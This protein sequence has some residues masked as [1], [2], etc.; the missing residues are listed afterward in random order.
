MVEKI[1][2][3]QSMAFRALRILGKFVLVFIEIIASIAS[4]SSSKPRYTASQAQE[5]YDEGLI[6]I[7]ELNK[8][9]HPK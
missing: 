1:K 9:I 8:S 5:L 2:L 3:Q 4:D 7:A 6:S